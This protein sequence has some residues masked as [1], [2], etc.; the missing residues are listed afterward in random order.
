M[1]QLLACAVNADAAQGGVAMML[2]RCT[3]MH[4]T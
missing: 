4:S 1:Q 2:L 3:V